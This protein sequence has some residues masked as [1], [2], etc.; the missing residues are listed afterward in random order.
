MQIHPAGLKQKGQQLQRHFE[1]M[2]LQDTERKIK[3]EAARH[4]EAIAWENG[5]RLLHELFTAKSNKV[6]ELDANQHYKVHGLT[7]TKP[8]HIKGAPGAKIELSGGL[9]I[10]DLKKEP[11]VREKC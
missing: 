6:I 1:E 4:R 11:R 2:Q 10:I 3:W 5:Q 9:I 8:V 7:I